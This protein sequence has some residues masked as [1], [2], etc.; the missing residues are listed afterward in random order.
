M[1]CLSTLAYFT[2]LVV[3]FCFTFRSSEVLNESHFTLFSLHSNLSLWL[4]NVVNEYFLVLHDYLSG[5]GN[6][7]FPWWFID[8]NQNLSR[9]L[10]NTWT[11]RSTKWATVY[12]LGCDGFDV[13]VKYGILLQALD[14]WGWSNLLD[15]P[16]YFPPLVISLR[17]SHGTQHYFNAPHD[18]LI[19]LPLAASW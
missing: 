9:V 14:R 13:K 2:L 17:Y 19:V 10:D 1:K 4:L 18:E 16:G 7:G 8:L 15:T 5:T 6:L 11:L 12:F 3:M